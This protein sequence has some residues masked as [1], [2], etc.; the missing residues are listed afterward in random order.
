M[1][2]KEIQ[3]LTDKI[4]ETARF[5]SETLGFKMI[6]TN[7]KTVSFTAG[8]SILT[9][10]QSDNLDP[11]YHFAFNIPC[12]KLDEAVKWISERTVLIKTSK[13]AV[14]ANFENWNAKAIYF[15]DNNGNILEFIA[16][17][18]LNNLDEHPFTI[19]SVQ[20]ISEIGLVTDEPLV[21]A[22][23]LNKENKLAYF[24]KGS[25]SDDFVAVG[26]DNGLFVIVKTDRNWYPTTMP[27][28]KFL[29][30]IR[31]RINNENAEMVFNDKDASP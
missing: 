12:N 22:V 6:Y 10:M 27:A 29:T 18:D 9:F 8:Q 4:E 31:L 23:E 11:K 14:I 24:S 3:I 13:D 20:S 5:Y 21:S 15:Y 2:I 17:Y 1:E 25:I 28:Q 26:N 19:S 16:R 30:K 7:A